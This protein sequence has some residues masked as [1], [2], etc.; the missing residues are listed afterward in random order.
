[1][2]E[3]FVEKD[4]EE[5]HLQ[6]TDENSHIMICFDDMEKFDAFIEKLLQQIDNLK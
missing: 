6:F 4:G 3:P 1:M 2:I 5:V